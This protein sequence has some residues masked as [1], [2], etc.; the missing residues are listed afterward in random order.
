MDM[1]SKMLASLGEFDFLLI[2][3]CITRNFILGWDNMAEIE[4]I[5]S[6]LG[7]KSPFL[8]VYV[9]GEFCP[10]YDADGKSI[11]RFHNTTL[12]SCAL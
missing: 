12:I 4:L 1:A 8:F 7:K 5:Q 6:S 10:V 9:A 11:N 2:A 3:S